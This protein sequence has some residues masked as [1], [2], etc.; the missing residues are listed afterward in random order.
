MKRLAIQWGLVVAVVFLFSGCNAKLNA[1]KTGLPG[2]K[3]EMRVVYVTPRDGYLEAT[4][5]MEGLTLVT[6]IPNNALCAGILT[7]DA[8]V[9]YVASSPGG[10]FRTGDRTCRSVGIGSLSVWRNRKPRPNNRGG[11]IVARAQADYRKVYEDS[12]VVFLRGRFP[13]ASKV[14]WVGLD[15]LIA[16]VPKHPNCE[17]PLARNTSSMEYYPAGRYVLTLVSTHGQCPIE[18]LITPYGDRFPENT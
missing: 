14:G 6:F 16:V 4:L 18:G 9:D 15:D 10:D 12:D 7:A 17:A 1:W 13:L 3:T 11:A 8:Q 2:W 5:A